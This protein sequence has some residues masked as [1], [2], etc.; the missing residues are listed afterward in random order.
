MRSR[1]LA[2]GAGGQQREGQQADLRSL[3]TRMHTSTCSRENTASLGGSVLVLNTGR[4]KGQLMKLLKD[5]EDVIA[6]PDV[7]ITAVGTKVGV[8]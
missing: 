7:L 5:K 1:Q 3:L 2:A 6:V 4:S 8:F